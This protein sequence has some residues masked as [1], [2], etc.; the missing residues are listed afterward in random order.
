MT[1]STPLGVKV[2]EGGEAALP[3]H[4][5]PPAPLRPAASA[6]DAA[7]RPR[8]EATP[9]DSA[10]GMVHA[11]GCTRLQ[12]EGAALLLVQSYGGEILARCR[13]AGVSVE[14]GEEVITDAVIRFLDTHKVPADC[15]KPQ[16]YFRQIYRNEIIDRLR[17]QARDPSRPMAWPFPAQGDA[18]EPFDPYAGL[19]ADPARSDPAVQ[20]EHR[21]LINLCLQALQDDP[22][23]AKLMAMFVDGVP[24]A[25]M[26]R[27]LRIKPGALRDRLY[28]VRQL[29]RARFQAFR[30]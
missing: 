12:R 11:P 22:A 13:A 10:L 6:A 2:T 29:L 24:Q 30:K 17:R 9:A 5:P 3:T 15:R 4:P 28:R 26:A 23:A 25:E 19:A 7:A 8:A 1:T 21:Q 27:R 14:D 20:A 16:A 18:V